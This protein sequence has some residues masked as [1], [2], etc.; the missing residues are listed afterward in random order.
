MSRGLLITAPDRT[1]LNSTS[2]VELSAVGRC[3]QALKDWRTARSI[4]CG[5]PPLSVLTATVFDSRVNLTLI[6]TLNLTPPKF[7]PAHGHQVN[8]V[9]H[10]V[11]FGMVKRYKSDCQ[12]SLLFSSLLFS[13]LRGRQL[14]SCLA[15]RPQI[16][17]NALP[18]TNQKPNN[19]G[20]GLY[21][22]SQTDN[23]IYCGPKTSPFHF[24]AVSTNGNHFYN[25]WPTVH[26]NNLQHN[27]YP[28]YL[29]RQ[30]SL[31]F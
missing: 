30:S 25:I 5:A 4:P 26:S 21:P 20:E 9:D 7:G 3:D 24:T 18:L 15:L 19:K 2:W 17:P 23:K 12:S 22:A 1:Q 27:N 11:K 10:Q 28:P 29:R 6:L 16:G 8:L 13:F 14:L 31:L